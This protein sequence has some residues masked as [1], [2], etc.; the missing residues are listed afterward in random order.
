MSKDGKER[1]LANLKMWKPGESGNPKGRVVGSKDKLNEAFLKALLNDFVEHGA[2]A[3]VACRTEKPEAYLAAISRVLP[4]D[5]NMQ[6]DG[7]A[8]FLKLLEA[9]TNGMDRGMVEEPG[10]SEALRDQRPAGHA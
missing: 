3:I 6:V 7:S 2:A 1:S 8:V 9:I 5:V 4:K 10:Q